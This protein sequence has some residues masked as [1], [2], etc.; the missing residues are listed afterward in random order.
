MWL[1]PLYPIERT[2]DSRVRSQFANGY[3]GS[4]SP[5]SVEVPKGNFDCMVLKRKVDVMREELEALS[6]KS[7]Q[8][9][10]PSRIDAQHAKGKLTA[11]ERIDLLFDEGTF[12]E[13]DAFVEHRATEFGMADRKYL[14]DAVVTGYGKIAGRV[15]FVYAQDFTVIGG[16]L[17]EVVAQKICKVMDLAAN[18]GA[19][20]VGL[21]DSGGA[22]IPGGHRQPCRIQRHLPAKRKI[23]RRFSPKYPPC[24][25]P[26]PAERSTLPP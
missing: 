4:T 10:G 18:S 9:G 22:R 15:A 11:R 20:V 5:P 24:S 14:G 19:P 25:A 1:R 12:E 2:A 23:L 8:G 13:L 21:I 6:E 16:T 17:S 3:G 26:P 7:R